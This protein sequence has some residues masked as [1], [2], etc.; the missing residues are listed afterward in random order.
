MHRRYALALI[1]LALAAVGFFGLYGRHFEPLTGDLTR[2]G[3][4]AENAYGWTLPD[5]RMLPPLAEKGRLDGA[6]DIVAFGDSFTV[7]E[8]D[9][10]GS[11]WPHF[12]AR[13]TGLR[14]GVFDAG[15][16]AL[17]AI[18]AGEGYRRHPPA[19]FVYE[20]VERSLVPRH[21]SG[22][23]RDCAAAAPTPTPRL[24]PRPLG[25]EPAAVERL[26]ERAWDDW[27]AS[28]AI[29]FLLQNAIRR[30]RGHET[31][32]A[33]LLEL[34]EEG[35]FS[36]HENRGL[37]VYGEDFNKFGWKDEDWD[38]ASCGLLRMQ[39]RVQADGRTAFLAMVVPD[40]LSVY[41][42][43]LTVRDFDRLSRLERVARVPGLNLVPLDDAFNPRRQ[44]DLYLPDD[45]HW[46]GTGHA[47]AAAR[48][49]DLMR[50]RGILR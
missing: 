3:W 33:V 7:D 1:G 43:Y 17:D 39:N 16:L 28:Y 4:Y 14:I 29:N 36:S 44:V 46:S 6:Y 35:L 27:P 11:N 50:R 30:L 2:I 9:R 8:W 21:G 48:I 24:A 38:A 19:V 23:P 5:H 49:L 12:L 25:Q 26:R 22:G 10:P 31:T 15:L 40:K 42:P 37:L 32:T 20:I 18:L 41:A 13:E 34:R 45:T 47:L